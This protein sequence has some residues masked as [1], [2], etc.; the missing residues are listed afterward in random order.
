MSQSCQ[1][2]KKSEPNT[3]LLDVNDL[4]ID[5]TCDLFSDQLPV[6]WPVI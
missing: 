6:M 1:L 5:V 2:K 4:M 3:S